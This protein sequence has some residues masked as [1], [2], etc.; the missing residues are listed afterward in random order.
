MRFRGRGLQCVCTPGLATLGALAAVAATLLLGARAESAA[1]ATTCTDTQLVPNVAELL[2]SQG[3][4]GYTRLARGKET[5]VRAYLTNPTT[6]TLSNRQSIAPVSATLDVSYSNGATAPPTPDMPWCVTGTCT[7]F[8]PL[9]GKLGTTTQIYSTSDPLFVVPA[10]YLAPNP[11]NPLAY[12]ITFKLKITYSRNGSTSY[13]TTTGN[14]TNAT[15]GPVPVDQKTNALRVLVVPM[16]DP[17]STSPQWS[18]LAESTLQTVMT[19]ASRAF[20]V[21]TGISSSLCDPAS[22]TCPLGA[23]GGIRYVVSTTLLDAKSLGL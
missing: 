9:S 5:I 16:G 10:T 20:P 7:N 1:S 12:D 22:P 6:C 14:E 8:A 21:P 2:V 3:A 17:T 15:K 4:P 23:T 18:S 19:N 11:A 13:Q